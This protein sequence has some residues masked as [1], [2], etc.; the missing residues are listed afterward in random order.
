MPILIVEDELRVRS[1]IARG[2]TEEGFRVRESKDGANAQEL[3]RS[4]RFDLVILDWRAP[5]LSGMDL[6][7]SMRAKQDLTPVVMLTARDAVT[8]RVS[9]LNAGAD[10]SLVKPFAFEELLA[11]VRAVLRRVDHRAS[12]YL[13]HADLSLDPT[14]RRVVRAGVEL[15]LTAREYALLKF[16]MEH[17]GEVVSRTRIVQA[18]WGHDFETFSNVVEVYIRYL[19]AKVDRPFGVRLIH[20][21]RGVGYVLRGRA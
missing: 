10:D 1:F 12:H 21:V 2:L 16:L 17:A 11:R 15:T 5:G 14:G 9:A 13:T 8:D 7:Q 3:L 18:V 4:E 6:L 19:R 20:T